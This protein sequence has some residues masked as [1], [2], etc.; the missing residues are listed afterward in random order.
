MK[1]HITDRRVIARR[2]RRKKLLLWQGQQLERR[3]QTIDRLISNL[4]KAIIL[5]REANH[6]TLS[7]QLKTDYENLV[8]WKNKRETEIE[9][10]Y[11]PGLCPFC[12]SSKWRHKGIE[13][14]GKV[15]FNCADCGNGGEYDPRPDYNYDYE[16][17]NA[18]R[19]R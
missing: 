13:A 11:P 14:D 19:P 16:A 5:L 9:K 17:Q 18:N 15:S 10:H 4:P 7:R 1:K 3:E 2:E 6:T 8:F 12:R